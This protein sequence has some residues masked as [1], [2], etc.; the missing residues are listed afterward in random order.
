MRILHVIR[1]LDP[2]EGGPPAVVSRLAAAQASRPG[3]RGVSVLHHPA[4]SRGPAFDAIPGFNLVQ[5]HEIAEPALNAWLGANLP[6]YD[7]VHL[8]GV[9]DSILVTTA[10]KARAAR[11][12]G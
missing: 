5:R 7:V 2:Y 9:W 4:G 12:R 6:N 1:R 3:V 11:V 8:H 10:S